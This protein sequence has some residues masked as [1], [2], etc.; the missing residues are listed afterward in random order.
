VF[1][2]VLEGMDVVKRV[3]ALETSPSNDRPTVDVVIADCGELP[4]GGKAPDEA[5]QA[6]PVAES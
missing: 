3:E 1:G 2:Q 4:S 5:A 6:E